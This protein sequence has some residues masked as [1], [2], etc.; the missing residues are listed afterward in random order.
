MQIQ[1][2]V[3]RLRDLVSRAILARVLRAYDGRWL[4]VGKPP[5][6]DQILA[7]PETSRQWREAWQ[8]RLSGMGASAAIGPPAPLLDSILDDYPGK[9]D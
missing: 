6:I 2:T 9:D 8:A 4:L 1:R 7:D 5:P 3:D